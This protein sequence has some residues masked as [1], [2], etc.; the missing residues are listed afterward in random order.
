MSKTN[1]MKLILERIKTLKNKPVNKPLLWRIGLI[2]LGAVLILDT[3]FIST[4]SNRNL[5]VILP[6]IIGTPLLIY[7]IFEAFFLRL[8]ERSKFA[9]FIKSLFILGYSSFLLAIIVTFS[10]ISQAANQ[11]PKPGAD[12]VIVLGAGIR[13]E[14]VRLLLAKRLNAAIE[15]QKDNPE[16][17][18]IV[19]GGQG[20][21]ET[22]TEAEAMKRYLVD[23]GV[24]ESSVIKEEASTSTQENFRFSKLLLD[25]LFTEEPYCV[26]VTSSFHVYRATRVAA[27]EG[28]NAAGIGSHTEWYALLNNYLRESLAIWG[29]SVLGWY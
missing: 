28:L 15:Y 22:I 6:A 21:G 26:F 12:A 13:G 8:E 4:I 19:S 10:M 27:K 17:I 18:I 11:T 25:D 14:E 7:G 5:G 2:V 3:L 24:A 9:R 1:K 20:D 29:Y 16:A 23:H